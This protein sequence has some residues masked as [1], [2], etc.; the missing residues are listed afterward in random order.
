M[1]EVSTMCKTVGK[2]LDSRKSQ[3]DKYLI[4]MRA[5][6]TLSSVYY[7]EYITFGDGDLTSTTLCWLS[8]MPFFTN[9]GKH[10]ATRGRQDRQIVD[11][12]SRSDTKH[13][14]VFTHFAL[15]IAI[16]FCLLSTIFF[17]KC[18]ET[19][20]HQEKARRKDRDTEI[21]DPDTY[22]VYYT[23]FRALKG[24]HTRFVDSGD[25]ISNSCNLG[26]M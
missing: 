24:I 11:T 2:Q 10:L 25:D 21:L 19:C 15:F 6:F 17:C 4:Q 18:R 20:G 12:D 1:H 23:Q 5:A 3:T 22:S 8:T 7:R 14:W 16:I 9:A 26:P 13:W